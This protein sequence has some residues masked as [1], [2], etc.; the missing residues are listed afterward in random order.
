MK[1][2]EIDS[3]NT[4]A[5]IGI[6]TISL[7]IGL[8]YL[9]KFVEKLDSNLGNLR[10]YLLQI[11]FLFDKSRSFLSY[12]HQIQINQNSMVLDAILMFLETTVQHRVAHF[13]CEYKLSSSN[14]LLQNVMNS[15][16]LLNKSI[17]NHS[18]EITALYSG[19]AKF[20]DLGK[21]PLNESLI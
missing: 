1:S 17:Y 6:T 20:L 13:T 11:N 14:Y 10:K 3:E 16:I 2:V 19:L 7:I 18:E 21:A 8:N 9:G 5:F 15:A 4:Y 12:I